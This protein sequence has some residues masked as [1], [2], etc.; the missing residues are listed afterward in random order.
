MIPLPKIDSQVTVKDS[1]N[2]KKLCC[3]IFCCNRTKTIKAADKEI[4]KVH[5]VGVEVLVETIPQNHHRRSVETIR[6]NELG[7]TYTLT[8]DDYI[9]LGKEEVVFK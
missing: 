9:F 4:V 2:C 5:A 3:I 6:M 7:S 8:Q 1:C